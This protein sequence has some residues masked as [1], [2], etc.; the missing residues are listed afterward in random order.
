MSFQDRTLISQVRCDNDNNKQ[1]IEEMVCDF[2]SIRIYNIY[3]YVLAS[4]SSC[5]SE[6][7]SLSFSHSLTHSLTHS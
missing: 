3:M 4:F 2:L 7:E 1:Y 6:N 5:N